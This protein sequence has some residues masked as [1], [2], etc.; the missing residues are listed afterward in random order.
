MKYERP[1]LLILTYSL[2]FFS[3]NIIDVSGFIDTSQS[4]KV[5]YG[6]ITLFEYSLFSLFLFLSIKNLKVRRY[7]FIL[8]VLFLVFLPIHIST[9]SMK[10]IDSIPI[11]IETLLILL[12]AS[13]YLFE[14][15]NDPKVLFIY[16]KYQ[17]WVII[18]FMLYLSG[19]FFMYIFANQIPHEK[20]LE[21]WFIIDIFLMVKNLCF[22][23][24]LILFVQQQK[25]KTPPSYPTLKATI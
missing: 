14:Q 20:I 22:S 3:C 23:M 7:I 11:G 18:G 21:Y 13:F 8:S 24:A 6:L 5:F 25:G 2:L 17:F 16:S 15:M 12:Y 19:S 1:L 10:R 4:R 9:A